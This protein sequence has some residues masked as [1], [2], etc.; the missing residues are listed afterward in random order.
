[1]LYMQTTPS[2]R[3][4]VQTERENRMID[5]VKEFVSYFIEAIL[6]IIFCTFVFI[7]I[8][9]SVIVSCIYFLYELFES[10]ED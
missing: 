5:K 10:I 7:G 3:R 9:I 2:L 1:M 4:Y 8:V 6:N